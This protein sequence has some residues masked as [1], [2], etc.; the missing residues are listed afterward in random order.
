MGNNFGFS[1]HSAELVASVGVVA[2]D[3]VGVFFADDVS[4][5]RDDFRVN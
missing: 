3:L 1:L 4:L 5:G 2:F